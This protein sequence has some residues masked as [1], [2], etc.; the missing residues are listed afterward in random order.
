MSDTQLSHNIRLTI[1]D[2]FGPELQ[3]PRWVEHFAKPI[4][5]G[6]A[7]GI[8]EPV[9]RRAFARPVGSSHPAD[10]GPCAFR[11]ICSAGSS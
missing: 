9:I 10:Q 1:W 6:D 2:E 4:A 7:M 8:A 3:K 5:F 11:L